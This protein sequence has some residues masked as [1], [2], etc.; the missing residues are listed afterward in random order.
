MVLRVCVIQIIKVTVLVSVIQTLLVDIR[1][2][3]NWCE[4]ILKCINLVFPLPQ[5]CLLYVNK[6]FNKSLS[7]GRGSFIEKY[8]LF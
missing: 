4:F 7:V 3:F 1:H 8:S 6:M 5:I 2:S